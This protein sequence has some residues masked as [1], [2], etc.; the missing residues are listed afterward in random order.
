MDSAILKAGPENN[1]SHYS[2]IL[3][4]GLT[5][6]FFCYKFAAAY[7][8][9]SVGAQN[10][11]RGTLPISLIIANLKKQYFFFFTG[12]VVGVLLFVCLFIC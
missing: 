12:G 11:G 6:R 8:L 3:I 5:A 9:V 7:S 10:S 4:R 1:T 2:G